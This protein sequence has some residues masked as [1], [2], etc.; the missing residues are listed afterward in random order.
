[1]S[2]RDRRV[3]RRAAQRQLSRLLSQELSPDAVHDHCLVTGCT[4]AGR[5]LAIGP[6]R[7]TLCPAHKAQLDL[8][9]DAPLAAAPTR[10]RDR[11]PTPA[12]HP[13]HGTVDAA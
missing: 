5:S 7:L 4:A 8:A 13:P 2:A 9:Y 12:A 1:M 3:R 10:R 6:A 11:R